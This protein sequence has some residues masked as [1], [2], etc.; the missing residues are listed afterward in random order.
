MFW[1]IELEHDVRI[2]PTQLSNDIKNTVIKELRQSVEGK[3]TEESGLILKVQDELI[4]IKD[5]F[6]SQRTGY[7]VFTVR[8]K[9]IVFNPR[10]G[11]IIHAII[12]TVNSQGITATAG[13]LDIFISADNLPDGYQPDHDYNTYKNEKYPNQVFQNGVKIRVRLLNVKRGNMKNESRSLFAIASAKG[14]GLGYFSN[15]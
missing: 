8:Y 12:K 7:G 13:P 1:D 3:I 15:R 5:G 4:E 14:V 10:P 9:A 6:V 11:R 2:H